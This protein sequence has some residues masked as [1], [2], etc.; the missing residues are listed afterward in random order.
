VLSDNESLDTPGKWSSG[1][2]SA[3]ERCRCSEAIQN[4][5]KDS[6]PLFLFRDAE[7]QTRSRAM[8][9]QLFTKKCP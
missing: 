4:T 2:E 9:F 3:Q 6:F 5:P 8:S 1:Q 7:R